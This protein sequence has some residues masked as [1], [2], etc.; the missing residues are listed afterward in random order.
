MSNKKTLK[1]NKNSKK[2][3]SR[4]G[5]FFGLF[6]DK[7]NEENPECNQDNL[8]NLTSTFDIKKNI[9][10]CC[11][12]TWYGRKNN[13]PYCKAV[14][15]KY[16]VLTTSYLNRMN[17]GNATGVIND[18]NDSNNF[19]PSDLEHLKSALYQHQVVGPDQI[20]CK[21]EKLAQS[22]TS[23]GKMEGYIET[24]ECNKKRWNPLSDKKANCAIVKKKLKEIT[25]KEEE[26]YKTFMGKYPPKKYDYTLEDLRNDPN[27]VKTRIKY[28]P[29][30]DYMRR[31]PP[32]FY[33]DYTYDDLRKDPNSVKQRI[34][35]KE[36]FFKQFMGDY[37]PEDYGYYTYDDLRNDPEGM[38]QKV[39]AI[40]EN[41]QKIDLV[42]DSGNETEELSDE[43][44][45]DVVD[46]RT[47]KG[48]Y[49]P[50]RTGGKRR[51]KKH[52]RKRSIGKRSIRKRK[53]KRRKTRKQ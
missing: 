4:K 43:D 1:R 30:N 27:D 26:V 8:N 6:K 52:F 51:T 37:P 46:Y 35:D 33:G 9:D 23:K 3:K 18:D 21:N 41:M 7:H 10:T 25:D 45:D 14:N 42:S 50:V 47:A 2:G 40:E 5:G 24:C 36:A 16:D 20:N 34:Q 11:P 32:K 19:R 49:E 28:K 12:K 44:E 22:L 38:K 48:I 31:Y 53:Q 29:I 15:Q 13:S 39:K 17:E